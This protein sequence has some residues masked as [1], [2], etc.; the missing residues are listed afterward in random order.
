M[1]IAAKIKEFIITYAQVLV[2]ALAFAFMNFLSYALMRNIEYKNLRRESDNMLSYMQAEVMSR[3]SE[4]KIAMKRV[5]N[6]VSLMIE[7]GEDADAIKKYATNFGEYWNFSQKIVNSY[8]FL[9]ESP[10]DSVWYKAA[11]EANGEVAFV[12]HLDKALNT[13]VVTYVC[14]IFDE[15]G[16]PRGFVGLNVKIDDIADY[17][18]NT[19]IAEGGFG[20]MLNGNLE[21]IAHPAREYW[22]KGL[23]EA[24]IGIT[25]FYE[26]FSLGK[27]ISER[28][29]VNHIGEE[30]LAFF[31][32]MENGWY[33][34]VVTAKNNYYKNIKEMSKYLIILG[35]AFTL[36]LSLILIRIINIRVRMNALIRSKSLEL[37]M[38]AHR[39]EF[40]LNSVPMPITVT[41]ID[42]KWTFINTAVEKFLGITLKEALGKP[43]SN[44]NSHICNTPDCGI[45]CV[46]RGLK[47][48]FFSHNGSSYKVDVEVLKGLENEPIGYVE[49]VQDVTKVE[50]M[51]KAE[52][53]SANKAKSLF[54]AKMSHEIRT[55]MNAI[56]GAVEIQIQD[57]TLPPHIK[58]SFTMIYNSSSLLLG[59]INDILDLSKIEAGKMELVLAKYGIASLVNDT[60]QLNIM[61]NSKRITFELFIDE[62]APAELFGDEIRIK[63]ILN[64]LLSNAFKYTEKGKIKLSIF[65]ENKKE[66]DIT[67]VFV[68]S[69]TGHGMTEEQVEKLFSTEY[70]RFNLESNRSI[71]GTGLGMSITQHLV[72]I[73]GG[74]ISLDSKLGKGSTF[75]VHLPQKIADPS[76]LGREMAE[77]LM[78]LRAI[79][80][81]VKK[82]QFIREYMPYG[83]VLIVDDVDS[84]L[85]VAK[86]LMMPYGLSI[87]TVPSGSAAINKVKNGKVYDIIFMDY[88][89]PQM[90]GMEAVKII[91]DL[92][93]K[94]PIVALTANALVG[95]AKIFLENGFDDFLP[96]PIDVRQLNTVLNRLVRNRQS[97]EA[98]AEAR[99]SKLSKGMEKLPIIES[100]I[101]TV[102]YSIFARDAKKALLVFESV[103]KNLANVSDE[104]LQLFIIKAHAMKSA[105][106]NI[107]E[108]AF[109]QVA[110]ALEIAGKERDKNTIMRET[111][112]LID[113]LK[114]II[115]KNEAETQ[116]KVTDK[117]ENAAYLAE[118]L[119]IIS[120]ACENYDAKT[121]ETAIEALTNM[122]WTKETKDILDKI[123]EHILHSDFE[124]AG[125]LAK[126]NS[127]LTI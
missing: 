29:L 110:L 65:T 102:S 66:D 107:G 27:D 22:G 114:S 124:E 84:N 12:D 85:F 63:Q 53:D 57:E 101:D 126:K 125:M 77:N 11:V 56:M 116:K 4:P 87:D 9:D 123:S 104:D 74:K 89:M 96:K 16:K 23:I 80:K 41:D 36:L 47:Q 43:C 21:I 10:E 70:I 31:R 24:N 33:S 75:T 95:Q 35:S 1:H 28:E 68:L 122:S 83:S 109:S 91:R 38:M 73:M 19:K 62:N 13:F 112:K 17:V 117:D 8:I 72:H 3:M 60:V 69:D 25:K 61:R 99:A 115:E 106:A 97:P 20:F 113:A 18:V 118:Q 108:A 120:D 50:Q 7:Q 98:I 42:A 48:T 71:G 15:A 119:K 39:Y 34:G 44:W 54:L 5:V 51:A 100:A 58:E 6:R 111:Q 127:I 46:K 40:I 94:H 32:K 59:I 52:A 92:G 81:V 30:A 82:A 26:D 103:L 2:V 45:E 86:G 49:V 67:L 105:L 79:D 121:A 76:A 14:R 37:E 78:Q 64:N 93:Y 55:P 88:M 90:D